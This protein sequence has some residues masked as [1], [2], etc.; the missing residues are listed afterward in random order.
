MRGHVNRRST[1]QFVVELGPQPLQR[2]PSCRK[3][4][5]S[6]RG[7]LHGCP[8]CDGPLE[9]RVER[10]QEFHTGYATEREAEEEL[11]R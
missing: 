9:G 8:K 11:A 3:R 7:R 2:C 10:R 5:W 1:W 4:Y 6:D